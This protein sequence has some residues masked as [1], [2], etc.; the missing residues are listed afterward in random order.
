MYVA[1]WVVSAGCITFRAMYCTSNNRPLCIIIRVVTGMVRDTSLP[2][3]ADQTPTLTE[4]LYPNQE[5]HRIAIFPIL[6]SVNVRKL[7]CA[8]ASPSLGRQLQ[9][10]TARKTDGVY[11][12]LTSMR[13]RIPWIEA[14]TMQREQENGPAK[15][16][17][18]PA[19]LSNRDLLPKKMSDSFHRVVCICTL[20]G[21]IRLT[22]WLNMQVIPLA[23]DPWLLDNYLNANGRIRCAVSKAECDSF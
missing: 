17:I 4:L 12:A 6:Q 9:I 13:V 14:L 15:L 18:P 16:P 1:H 20:I 7:I 2:C 21:Y 11:K 3:W 19:G 23:Q 5:M 8:I 10:T 22:T